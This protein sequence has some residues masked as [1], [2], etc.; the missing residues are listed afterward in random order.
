MYLEFIPTRRGG[1]VKIRGD[2]NTLHLIERLL[3]K[4]AMSSH[5]VVN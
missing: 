2:D 4:H 5:V 3:T 1:G